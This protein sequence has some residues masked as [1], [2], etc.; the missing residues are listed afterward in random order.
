MVDEIPNPKAPGAPVSPV[1]SVELLVTRFSV[2]AQEARKYVV[3]L[4]LQA[5][6]DGSVAALTTATTHILTIESRTAR[7]AHTIRLRVMAAA[8]RLA[9][10]LDRGE[11]LRRLHALERH[12]LVHLRWLRD[13]RLE[14]EISRS[15]IVNKDSRVASI[16]VRTGREVRVVLRGLRAHDTQKG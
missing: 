1:Q 15:K 4:C 12:M 11:A 16:V 8:A 14:I 6:A 10:A 5:M 3:Q 2:R 9:N 7:E 13:K